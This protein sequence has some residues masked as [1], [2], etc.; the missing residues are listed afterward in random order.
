M[1]KWQCIVCG[2]IYNEADGWPDDGIAPGQNS[3]IGRG[4]VHG[5]TF[6]SEASQYARGQKQ[7]CRP[8]GRQASDASFVKTGPKASDTQP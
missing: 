6:E 7:Q 2:L 1:K 3:G 8:E 5:V 4:H